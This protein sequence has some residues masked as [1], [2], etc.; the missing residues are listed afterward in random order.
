MSQAN[1]KSYRNSELIPAPKETLWLIQSGIVR[2]TI[3]TMQGKV[4]ALGYWGKDDI[5]G[6]PLNTVETLQIECIT[7]VQVVPILRDE[8]SLYLPAILHHSEQTTRLMSYVIQE[9]VAQRLVNVLGWLG[10]RFGVCVDSGLLIDLPLSHTALSELIGSTR[11]SVT[12]LLG[13]FAV[14]EAISQYRKK[15][16]ILLK[17]LS[18]L[19]IVSITCQ[20]NQ[21][22]K[23]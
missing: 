12:R 6:H 16:I 11:V 1:P 7:D 8:W 22:Q 3:F 19:D 20:L 21:H 15:R 17:D 9:S 2:T 10:S 5:V 14:E 18:S 4:T 23:T 13:L